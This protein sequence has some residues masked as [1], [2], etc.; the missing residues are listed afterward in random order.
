MKVLK[1]YF[2][3]TCQ[4]ISAA[5]GTEGND[6]FLMMKRIF[7]IKED[8]QDFFLQDSEGR[9]VILPKHLPDELSLF[10]YVRPTYDAISSN[11]MS[12]KTKSESESESSN[13]TTPLMKALLEKSKDMTLVQFLLKAGAKL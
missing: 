12:C 6:I 9:I 10:L 5:D 8:I 4:E 1:I 3:G 7:K 11:S 2:R 13:E